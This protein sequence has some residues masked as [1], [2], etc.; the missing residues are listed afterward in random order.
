MRTSKIFIAG[1]V[2]HK[3]TLRKNRRG[4][5]FVVVTVCTNRFSLIEGHWYKMTDKHTVMAW[6]NNA[7]LCEKYLEI[8]GSLAVDGYIEV[9]EAGK[10]MIIAE[11]LHFLGLRTTTDDLHDMKIHRTIDIKAAST[12]L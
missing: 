7:Q 10:P 9:A 6:D 2:V 8:G 12:K 1:N 3:P 11:N 5:P 4:R